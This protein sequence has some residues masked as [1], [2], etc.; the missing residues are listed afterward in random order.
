MGRNK[1]SPDDGSLGSLFNVSCF[2]ISPRPA[3]LCSLPYPHLYTRSALAR[4]MLPPLCLVLERQVPI[5]TVHPSTSWLD[6]PRLCA[7]HHTAPLLNSTSSVCIASRS[8]HHSE[9]VSPLSFARMSHFPCSSIVS[10]F[11]LSS[12]SLLVAPESPHS[13]PFYRRYNPQYSAPRPHT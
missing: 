8:S 9:I 3:K 5:C 2:R 10:I 7:L 12:I 4:S 6:V 1:S 13:H 11:P